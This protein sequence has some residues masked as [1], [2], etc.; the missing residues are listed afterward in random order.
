MRTRDKILILLVAVTLIL[1]AVISFYS[2]D[3]DAE[4]IRFRWFLFNNPTGLV[5]DEVLSPANSTA[6]WYGGIALAAIVMIGVVLR[7]A[8]GGELRA[9][10]ER[11]VQAEVAKAELETLLQ[12]VL[13]RE[14]HAR[15][16]KDAA[17]KDL[18][19]SL[20]RLLVLEHQLTDNERILK[21]RDGELS[22]LRSQVRAVTEQPGKIPLAKLQEQGAL[23]DEL[24]KKTEALEAKDSALKQLEKSLAGKVHALETQLS[25]KEKLL[26]DRDMELEALRAEMNALTGKLADLESTNEQAEN[27]WQREL[28]QKTEILQR[29]EASITQ[30]E[31][32]LNGKIQ[33]LESRLSEKQEALQ[34]RTTELDA[35]R[36]EVNA[37]TGKLADLESTREQAENAWQQELKQKAEILQRKEAAITQLEKSLNGKIQALESRLSEKQEALQNRT[38]EL[39]A[40]RAEVNAL[41]GKLADLESTR[42]Q[43]E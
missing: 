9:F 38:T 24:R 42:E 29:K 10:R 27:A 39:D 26:T 32:S 20:S 6:L 21:I 23:R 30:L 8:F 31:K 19:A 17:V 34:N 41:T 13:W 37:L 18:D 7:T 43:A 16:A 14:K 40:L 35:L 12:D 3:N 5:R 28:K 36:A 1:G 2:S 33:A 4:L 11:L 25:V 15:A 22:T